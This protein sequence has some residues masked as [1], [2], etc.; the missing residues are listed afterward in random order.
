M[1]ENRLNAELLGDVVLARASD[2]ADDSVATATAF[3]PARFPHWV[4]RIRYRCMACHPGLFE[5][6]V[7][8]STLTMAELQSGGA[9]G[10]CHNGREAFSLFNCD[11]CHVPV[12]AERDSVP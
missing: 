10:S 8:A 2:S 3:P 12:Q 7:G 1:P 5:E 11:R 9:C 4:H 6:R